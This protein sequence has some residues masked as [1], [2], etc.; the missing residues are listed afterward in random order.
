MEASLPIRKEIFYVLAGA[1]SLL[2]VYWLF[3]S[4]P[5]NFPSGTV[6]AIEPGTTLRSVSRN[7]KE[8]NIIRS[9]VAFE[10]GV[11]LLHG[12][13]KIISGNYLFK[14]TLPIWSVANRIATGKRGQK[15]LKITIPEGFDRTQIAEILSGK[16]VS[17]DSEEFMRLSA[18]EEGYLFPDTYFFYNVDDAAQVIAVMNANFK[19]K[20]DSLRGDILKSGYTEKE[21]I[22]MASLVER[23]A[24]GDA[25]REMIAG[26]LWKR[27]KNNILLQADAAPITYE[28]R[29]LPEDPIANPGLL[30]IKAAIFPKSSPYL[31]YLHD[32]E[33]NIY[34]AKTFE[35]HKINKAKYLK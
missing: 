25:D 29:G 4:P 14:D 19:K 28:K 18:E 21:I 31:Y 26:I 10:A 34:Y 22:V 13:K 33:G 9:R 12:K 32:A 35:E 8:Q 11:I 20:I 16:L 17:F 27:L 6:V 24:D 15:A 7:L 2:L 5:R 3:L 1:V 23:E 30:A